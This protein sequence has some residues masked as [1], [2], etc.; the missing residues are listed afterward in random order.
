MHTVLVSGDLLAASRVEGEARRVGITF[1]IVASAEAAIDLCSR[2]LVGLVIVDLATSGLDLPTLVDKLGRTGEIR[3]RMVAFGPH[4]HEARLEAAANAG[5]DE[6]L[7]RGQFMAQ[8]GAILARNATE[9][10]QED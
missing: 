5:F 10:Q 3:P 4:V 6:V 2:E 7:S 1:D 9:E 8:I